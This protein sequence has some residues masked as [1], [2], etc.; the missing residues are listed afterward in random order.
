MVLWKSCIITTSVKILSQAVLLHYLHPVSAILASITFL[1]CHTLLSPIH[2][3]VFSAEEP[4]GAFCA[5]VTT[6]NDDDETGG[7]L[8]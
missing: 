4:I 7:L 1:S 3:T 8:L 5:V 6:V 2:H